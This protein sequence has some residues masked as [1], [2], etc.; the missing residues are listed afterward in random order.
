MGYTLK[1]GGLGLTVFTAVALGTAAGNM[2]PSWLDKAPDYN[3]IPILDV[4]PAE[5]AAERA[6]QAK[7][8]AFIPVPATEGPRKGITCLMPEQNP[9]D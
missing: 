8:G 6:C 4:S 3:N 5:L 7:G 9:Q 2:L 1:L